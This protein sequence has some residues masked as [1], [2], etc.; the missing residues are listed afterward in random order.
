MLFASSSPADCV[1]FGETRNSSLMFM[2]S[3]YENPP[4]QLV[5]QNAF[6]RRLP[7]SVRFCLGQRFEFHFAIIRCW[8][9]DVEHSTF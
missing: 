2:T 1:R 9:L 8:T 5:K 6:L 4:R 7:V 3:H